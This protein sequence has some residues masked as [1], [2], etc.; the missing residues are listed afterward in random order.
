MVKEQKGNERRLLIFFVG[1]W[2]ENVMSGKRLKEFFKLS[3][4]STTTLVHKKLKTM[5]YRDSCG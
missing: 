3:V 4:L 1:F 2:D 5:H